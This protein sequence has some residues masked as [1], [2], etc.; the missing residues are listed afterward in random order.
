MKKENN[1]R[2]RSS[3]ST[4]RGTSEDA[5]RS[6]Y[7]CFYERSAAKKKRK[8]KKTKKNNNKRREVEEEEAAEFG[9][10]VCLPQF[11]ICVNPNE[12]RP[13]CDCDSSQIQLNFGQTNTTHTRHTRHN[14][15]RTQLGQENKLQ[16][17]TNS[18]NETCVFPRVFTIF[19][20][21]NK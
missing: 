12:P 10:L 15:H 9:W 2:A 4:W 13:D 8:E 1:K 6:P 20:H 11:E 5:S 17:A 16:L 3:S 14:T 21:I 18:L 7:L 19:L